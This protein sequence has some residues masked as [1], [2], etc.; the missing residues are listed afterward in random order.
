MPGGTGPLKGVCFST[1]LLSRKTR[2][3]HTLQDDAGK[4]WTSHTLVIL[5]LELLVLRYSSKRLDAYL[6]VGRPTPEGTDHE[7]NI[8]ATIVLIVP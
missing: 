5:T 4:L 6:R 7:E 2:H 3:P 8:M 1:P